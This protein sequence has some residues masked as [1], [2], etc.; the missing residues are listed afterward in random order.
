MKSPQTMFRLSPAA[1]LSLAAL[2]VASVGLL[3]LPALA[4]PMG[5]QGGGMHAG[6]G[7]HPGMG[8]MGG[9][10]GHG[11]PMHLSERVLDQVKATPEQKA[12]VK[13]IMEAA[14]KDMQAQHDARRALRDEAQ[15]VFTAPNVDANAVESLRQK[16]LAL[17]DQASR[18]MSQAMLEASRVLTPEQRK[19][20]A[21]RMKQRQ[22]LMERHQQERRALEAPKT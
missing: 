11:G 2:L 12:Q 5:M 8:G 9:R 18:R 16:Q 15:R 7:G 10:M 17:H 22:Q 1:R 4:Q 3:A 14:H 21:D 6:P 13:Q 19:Q 20:L